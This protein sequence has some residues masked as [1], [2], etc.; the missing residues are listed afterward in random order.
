G[1]GHGAVPLAVEGVGGLEHIG[2]TGHGAGGADGP[3]DGVVDHLEGDADAVGVGQLQLVPGGGAVGERR[4]E[5]E[6]M[7]GA[8][9]A[10]DVADL[11]R[12]G[13]GG[14]QG[15]APRV[16]ARVPDEVGGVNEGGGGA[17]GRGGEDVDVPDHGQ[18][19]PAQ[20]LTGDAHQESAGVG[21]RW[22]RAAGR[23]GP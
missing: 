14:E 23:G 6:G 18:H 5:G 21:A 20:V 8:V 19:H 10:R 2:D 17:V 16:P 7:G 4:L 22:G 1:E 11:P 15:V 12:V 3:V 13:A 9:V